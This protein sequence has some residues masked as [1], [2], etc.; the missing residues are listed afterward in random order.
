MA[1]QAI[2][3]DADANGTGTVSDMAYSR[4]KMDAY[5]SQSIYDSTKTLRKD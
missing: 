5:D 2:T 1:T 3:V 4:S